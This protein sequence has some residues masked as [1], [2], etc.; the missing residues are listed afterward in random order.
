MEWGIGQV[1]PLKKDFSQLLQ[2]GLIGYD[3]WQVSDNG[4][5]ASP[6]IPAN[7]LP[8]YSFHAIGFQTNFILPA[9]ALNFFFKFEDEY[10]AFATPEGR[11]I[12]FGGSYTFRIPKPQAPHSR[13][14]SPGDAV[15][16]SLS[17]QLVG[18]L[19]RIAMLLLAAEGHSAKR[20]RFS[21]EKIREKRDKSM[22]T[23]VGNF[24]SFEC[25]M[26]MRVESVRFVGVG[27][28]LPSNRVKLRVC[29]RNA[30]DVSLTQDL[31]RRFQMRLG[32][33]LL[34]FG[35]A[36][37]VATML[38]TLPAAAQQKPNIVFILVDNV[39]WGAFGAYGGT[40]PTPRI[41]KMASEGIRFNNYNVESQ[42]TPT[43]SALMTG[44]YSIRSGTYTVPFPG[45]G[46]AGMAPWEYTIA[47]LLSDAGYATALYGKW[48]LGEHSG[49][50]PSDQGF[51][52]WW[53][54]KNSLDEAGYTAWP[55]FK[56]SG[57]PVPMIWEGK[58]GEPS[59]PVMPLDLKVRPVLDGQYI[60]PKTVEYIKRNAAAKKPFFVYV[61]TPSSIRRLLP[62]RISSASPLSEVGCLPTSS[63]RWTTASVRSWTPSRKRALTTT[64]S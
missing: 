62:T 3:Q 4:G 56:E 27:N 63:L 13:P 5:L 49:R 22:G 34:T 21:A 50:L 51:D 1:L 10:R 53:G 35:G 38:A 14:E 11:T 19:R 26:P 48:H 2:L 29:K 42:C 57:I 44:R 33:K 64:P 24:P 30:R 46:E 25:F 41:D 23:P 60:I 28:P 55:L 37:L 7:R 31:K 17:R 58:K 8:Y 15:I 47:E 16:G 36:L 9:K 40:I 43:R 6:N 59:K 32:E 45:Q 54:I 39:G 12:V 18:R 20:S 61:A 52:E